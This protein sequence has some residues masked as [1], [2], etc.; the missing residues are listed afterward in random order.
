MTRTTWTSAMRWT[1][2]LRRRDRRRRLRRR[3]CGRRRRRTLRRCCRCRRHHLR[4]RRRCHCWPPVRCKGLGEMMPAQLK[5]TTMDPKKR[6]LLKV[7][8]VPEDRADTQRSVERLMGTKAEAR[9]SPITRSDPT[10]LGSPLVS[11]P[12]FT[13]CRGPVDPGR[14]TAGRRE[15]A[16][17]ASQKGPAI[18]DGSQSREKRQSKSVRGSV[19]CRN[20]HTERK[21][22]LAHEPFR[23]PAA[24]HE[25]KRPVRRNHFPEPMK[26]A[27]NKDRL[28]DVPVV[29]QGASK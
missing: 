8:L 2:P 29:K 11:V 10:G 24:R 20:S 15:A 4:S 3:P 9:F 18:G 17:S 7:M 5:E 12:G 26:P 16:D 6:T 14:R 1:R 28:T 25:A 21:T 22:L 23:N 19:M 27:R 13:G